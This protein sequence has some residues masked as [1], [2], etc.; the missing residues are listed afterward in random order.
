MDGAKAVNVKRDTRMADDTARIYRSAE[1]Q[2]PE[3]HY[4]EYPGC[5]K[6]GAL[7]YDVDQGSQWFCFEH[8]WDDHRL[9]KARRS[10]FDDEAS[11]IDAIMAEPRAATRR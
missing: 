3:T 7:G 6:W 11:G 4:C 9:G 1:E 5:V 8:K 10:F 2:A